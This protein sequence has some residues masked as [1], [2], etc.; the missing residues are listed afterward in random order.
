MNGKFYL[1]T[2][3]DY[4]NAP[5]HLG[6]AYEK[7]TADCIARS[8]RALG[9]DVRFLIGNDEHGTKMEKSA[10]ALGVTPQ[11]YVD[12]MDAVYRGTYEKLLIRWDEFIRTSEPRHHVGVREILR[13]VQDAGYLRKAKYEGWYCEGCEAFYTEK[14]LEDGKCP[15]HQTQPR[16]VEE[17]NFFFRLSDFREPLLEHIRAH[18]DFIRPETRRNEVVAFLEGGLEDLSISRAG[19]TW[20]IP[21]PDEPG[22]VVYVWFDALTNYISGIGFGSDEEKFGKWWPCDVHIVGKDITRFHCVIWPAMLMA[23]GL[24]LPRSIFGHGFIYQAGVKMSKSLGNIVDPLDVIGVTGPD[25]LRYFL[26][27]EFTFGKDGDFSWD[28]FIGR[29]NADLANDLG[30]LVKRTTDMTVKFV[31]GRIAAGASGGG[32]RTGLKAVAAEVVREASSAYEAFDLSRAVAA[33]WTLV[34]SANQ[35]IQETKPWEIARDESR[36]EELSGVLSELLEAI[37]IVSELAEPAI[38]GKSP[39]IRER[40]GLPAASLGPWE[41][42]AAWRDSP[43]WSVTSGEPIFPRI[44]R[45][46]TGG[47]AAADPG[48]ATGKKPPKKKKAKAKGPAESIEFAQFQDVDLRVATVLAVERVEGADRLLKLQLDLGS[49]KRQVVSGI[50]EHFRP[51]DLP[52]RQV[53]LVANLAPAKIRGIESQGMI[54]VAQADG[55]MTLLSPGGDMAAGARVS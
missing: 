45:K 24:E 52:G 46:E 25:A 3:I 31:D 26:I 37:R 14:D 36:T 34:R 9:W 21:F 35:A 19:V 53:V 30:N 13:R 50:A 6:H 33:V 23:A 22:H 17:E 4:V 38:P 42:S 5:P 29:Y 8:R 55:R 54:L 12:K 7:V 39:E 27:R 28:A 32:D 49:E 10:A 51:E 41:Q 47:D 20:G 18:P 2:A 44:D 43:A 16:W 48:Q 11:Q 15:N 1:T 40:L